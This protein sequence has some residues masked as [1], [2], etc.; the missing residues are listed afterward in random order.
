M[1]CIEIK[2][3]S[4]HLNIFKKKYFFTILL[5]KVFSTVIVHYNQDW[6]NVV[7]IFVYNEHSLIQE[8]FKSVNIPLETEL[9]TLCY[10]YLIDCI[11][12]QYILVA[13]H[14]FGYEVVVAVEWISKIKIYKFQ[15]YFMNL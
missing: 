9:V 13:I 5:H 1:L 6:S 3:R 12:L 2:T 7:T 15:I 10:A 4:E 11:S 14:M 8:L